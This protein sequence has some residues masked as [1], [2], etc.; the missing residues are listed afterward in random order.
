M[1][2][3]GNANLRLGQE[4]MNVN[5]GMNLAGAKL[6]STLATAPASTSAR[7]GAKEHINFIETC[8]LFVVSNH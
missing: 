7:A 4:S 1:P 6:G 2:G 3:D 8:C 5:A